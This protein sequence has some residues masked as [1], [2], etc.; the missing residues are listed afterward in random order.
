MRWSFS[1]LVTRLRALSWRLCFWSYGRDEQSAKPDDVVE[2]LS[3]TPMPLNIAGAQ[4]F[5]IETKVT[6]VTRETYDALLYGLPTPD[7][8][9]TGGID[10]AEESSAAK[11]LDSIR[12]GGQSVL[13]SVRQRIG[14]A[15]AALESGDFLAAA[16]RLNECS[17]L[18]TP[19]ASAQHHLSLA[20]GAYLIR[21]KQLEAGMTISRI[22][23]IESIDRDAC[24]HESC[25]GHYLV[26]IENNEAQVLLDGDTNI[27]VEA[28]ES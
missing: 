3:A 7:T 24:D 13:L 11:M 18:I 21:A 27:Y 19:L 12:G 16:A 4:S 26:H 14:E 2:F 25:Q 15:V 23:R 22:G 6:E 9:D 1:G 17:N 10:M 20:D 5:H 8:T 28:A